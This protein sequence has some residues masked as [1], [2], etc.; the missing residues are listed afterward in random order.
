MYL[1]RRTL[2]CLTL[3]AAA[4]ALAPD[5]YPQATSAAASPPSG[6]TTF[7]PLA[8]VHRGLHGTAWTVFEGVTPEPMD[9]EILGV[10]RGALGPRQD[11]ILARLHGPKPEYTGVVAGMSGSPVY[12]DGK[13]VGALSYRIGQFSRE[14]IAGITP[15][16]QMLEVRDLSDRH[17]ATPNPHPA[18]SAAEA[19]T[20]TAAGKAAVE[21]I[22]TPLVFSGFSRE[23]I[24]RFASRFT[25]AGLT[26][27]SGL[28]GS[29]PAAAP[30]PP[31]VPGSAVSAI[32]AAGDLSI[33]GTCTVTYVDPK[34]LLA[35]GHP[36]TQYGA[37][38]LPMTKAEVVAT[39]PSPLNSFK[40]VNTTETIGAFTED[41]QSAIFGR[42]GET[43]RMI[44]VTVAITPA[45]GSSEL[46]RTY[47][48]QVLNNPQLTPSVM[49]V[50]VYQTLQNTD[51]AAA[52]LSYQLRGSLDVAAEAAGAPELH[53][54]LDGILTQNDFNPAAINAA[55][56]LND[57]FSRV[58]GNVSDPPLVRSV[59]LH[60]QILPGR[61]TA[62]IEAAS[63][64]RAEVSPGETLAIDWSLHP[65]RQPVQHM[66]ARVTLP[67]SLASG[68]LRLL[69]SDGATLDRLLSSSGPAKDS[70]LADTVRQLRETHPDDQVYVSV[71]DHQAQ[72]VLASGSLTDL[73][74]SVA[75]VLDPLKTTRSIQL[76][77]ESV[78]TLAALPAAYAV[79]GS[80]VV[81]LVVR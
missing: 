56:F 21:P 40:I 81:D 72:A 22:E 19:T 44:P 7:F 15:I 69:V 77:G 59:D 33:A 37:V 42:L 52:E 80:E 43:A 68:P 48:F 57:R 11:M 49:L 36:I 9:V 27:V 10:L 53:V 24:D 26:P 34:Q 20:A 35:C 4:I 47:H 1:P 31:L 64:D 14:A 28:G 67:P 55:L 58:Y 16:Q 78:R 71:L 45:P 32:L 79:T 13:L 41:R 75:S 73:P 38:S 3:A 63:A 25:A 61:R 8:E 66:E 62:A 2:R 17:A 12:I 54:P 70:S 30:T 5:L 46:P 23:V 39:L 50:S 76:N 65:Y 29:D 51:L 74:I 18:T 60:F 6:P